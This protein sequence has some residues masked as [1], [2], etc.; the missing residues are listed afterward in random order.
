MGRSVQERR[1]REEVTTHHI[2][3]AQWAQIE[4]RVRRVQFEFNPKWK[5]LI[6]GKAWKQCTEHCVEDQEAIIAATR[7]R[8]ST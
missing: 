1:G 4:S 2:S 8:I 5:C 6:D 3:R 7:E